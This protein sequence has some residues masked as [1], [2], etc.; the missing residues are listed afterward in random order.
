M[1]F[2]ISIDGKTIHFADSFEDANRS[3]K[4]HLEATPDRNVVIEK[5]HSDARVPIMIYGL[6][7]ESG[8][9]EE[10]PRS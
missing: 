7:K 4:G 9:F 6:N 1:K 3:A 5:Y 2:G 8:E 10:I